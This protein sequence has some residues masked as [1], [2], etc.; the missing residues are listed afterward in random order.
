[1]VEW[2]RGMGKEARGTMNDTRKYKLPQVTQQAWA[3]E[4]L[5]LWQFS[6][7]YLDKAILHFVWKVPQVGAWLQ[8]HGI[9]G[10]AHLS[11]SNLELKNLSV[12][13]SLS[14]KISSQKK[15]FSFQTMTQALKPLEA[16]NSSKKK[17]IRDC[18]LLLPSLLIV[19][20]KTGSSPGGQLSVAW[21]ALQFPGITWD[22]T[23]L[24][25]IINNLLVESKSHWNLRLKH[26][27]ESR[28]SL[29]LTFS[30]N[31]HRAKD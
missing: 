16:L 20:K 15:F 4:F 6:E 26:L 19:Q 23:C 30:K 8:S 21:G 12:R 24:G 11:R 25:S 9:L 18:L 22:K 10:L 13:F 3:E 17:K 5:S 2:G 1:M 29:N 31:K 14:F 28:S 7:K 27:R